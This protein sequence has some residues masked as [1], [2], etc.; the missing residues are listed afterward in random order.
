MIYLFTDFGA[1]D[2]YV[3]QVKSRLALH[4]PDVP[5]IDLLHEAAIFRVSAGAHMLCALATELPRGS[6][7]L[8]IVD[9]GVGTAR[10]PIAAHMR[11][12]WFVGPDNGLLSVLAARS[13]NVSLQEIV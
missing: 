6:V 12:C 4:A 9:P 7:I 5:V 8:A 11:D 3:G 2:I 1:A 10:R 13:A